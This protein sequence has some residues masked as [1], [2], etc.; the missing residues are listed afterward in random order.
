MSISKK[1]L[2]EIRAIKDSDIDYSEIPELGASFWKKARLV[3][4]E[5]KKAISLRVDRGVL[6]WFRSQGSGYQSLMNAVLKSFVEAR[7]GAHG[8]K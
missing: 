3:M 7:K 2:R 6:D 8:V 1:R 5:P 4:P